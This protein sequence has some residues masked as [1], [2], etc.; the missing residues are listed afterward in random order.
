MPISA[1]KVKL[2]ERFAS[3][4]ARVV[5]D[6]LQRAYTIASWDWMEY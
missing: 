6:L 1:F 5:Q 3:G 2:K 4:A